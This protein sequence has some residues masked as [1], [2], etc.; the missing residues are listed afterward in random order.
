MLIL[1][2]GES[3]VGKERK[4]IGNR[5]GISKNQLLLLHH[6]ALHKFYVSV[7]LMTL[8]GTLKNLR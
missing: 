5:D 6:V 1:E 7:M 3:S 8:H 4:I 2:F